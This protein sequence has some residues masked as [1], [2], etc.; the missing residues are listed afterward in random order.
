MSAQ[1]RWLQLRLLHRTANKAPHS[2]QLL[3]R[4]HQLSRSHPGHHTFSHF[5]YSI[6]A[7]KE[8]NL[9]A[10]T[11]EIWRTICAAP[12]AC[13][14]LDGSIQARFFRSRSESD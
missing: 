1:L 4:Y 11:L 8:G 5:C 12:A 7:Y 6:Q 3:E 10:G 2:R 9:R 14:W 13:G